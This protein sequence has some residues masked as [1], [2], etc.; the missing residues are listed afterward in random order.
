MNRTDLQAIG[1]SFGL[2]GWFI[3]GTPY[4]S[5]HINDTYAVLYD[6]GGEIV[7]YVLQRVNRSVFR[8]VPAVMENVD[9]VTRHLRTAL[10]EQRVPDR[11]R[12]AMNLL[13]TSDGDI[14][15]VDPAGEYWRAYEFVE[16]ASSYDVLATHDQAYEVARAFGTF[17]TMLADLPDPPLHETIPRFHDGQDRFRA[18]TAALKRDP[19]NRAGSARS[20]IAFLVDNAAIFDRFPALVDSGTVP[21]RVTHNDCKSNN[22]LIDDAT[23]EGICVIDLDTLMPGLVLY[24]FGDMVRTGTC[25]VAEDWQVLDDVHMDLERFE[26]LTRGYL[27]SAGGFLT[28]AEIDELAFSG[29]AITLTL[30]ARFL[31]DFLLGDTYFKTHR[32]DHNLERCRVQFELVRSMAAQEAAMHAVVMRAAADR[33][34]PRRSADLSVR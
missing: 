22:V 20:E 16:G 21:L 6:E 13:P 2:P 24:D 5:G 32:P 14:Y 15:H 18:F 27:S 12:R 33:G 1:A 19:L 8:D 23:G 3:D 28:A 4:G 7:R 31:T 34:T 30:G 9:R 10:E 17:Q 11:A 26:S 25:A 29:Q